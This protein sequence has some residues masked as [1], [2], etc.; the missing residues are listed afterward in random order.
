[1]KFYHSEKQKTVYAA[2]DPHVRSKKATKGEIIEYIIS[3]EI[4]ITSANYSPGDRV[5]S[6]PQ[7]IY[8]ARKDNE[9]NALG[10]F[11][12]NHEPRGK[13]IDKETYLK[14]RTQYEKEA[15]KKE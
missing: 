1:M 11:L 12:L 15:K 3:M 10:Y 7:E 9:K 13:E 5:R 8:D 6:Y 14:L 4:E 2:E